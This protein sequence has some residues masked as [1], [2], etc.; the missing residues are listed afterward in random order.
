METT[1]VNYFR[2]LNP[3]QKR[4]LAIAC[5]TTPEYLS[6]QA[7]LIG[8]GKASSLFKPAICSAIEIFSCGAVTRK[9][10]RPNDW[11]DIWIELR[12]PV[13]A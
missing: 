6:K 7:T 3:E 9:D 10:L 5:N 13:T 11:S 2:A 12:E 4:E 8:K 1:F